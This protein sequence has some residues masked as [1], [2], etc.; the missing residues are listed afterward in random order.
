M[1]EE[2]SVPPG[3]RRPSP[4]TDSDDYED[5]D[6]ELLLAAAGPSGSQSTPSTGPSTSAGARRKTRKKRERAC[7]WCRHRKVA[8][9]GFARP[10]GRCSLCERPSTVSRV[11]RAGQAFADRGTAPADALQARTSAARM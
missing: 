6:H 11:D 9:D 2:L 5:G 3:S 1:P 7:D 4:D 8:C 10:Q